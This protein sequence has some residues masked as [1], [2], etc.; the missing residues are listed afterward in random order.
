M[1]VKILKSNKWLHFR[2]RFRFEFHYCCYYY[3]CDATKRNNCL[4]FIKKFHCRCHNFVKSMQDA[5]NL[6]FWFVFATFKII[7][8]WKQLIGFASKRLFLFDLSERKQDELGE[9]PPKNKR[10]EK[11]L[12][13]KLCFHLILFSC[14]EVVTFTP[15]IC[16]SNESDFLLNVT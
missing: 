9:T 8:R 2:E 6:R 5:S 4:N 16:S 13:L 7:F 12:F 10:T 1:D 14:L 11:K 3:D 15:T